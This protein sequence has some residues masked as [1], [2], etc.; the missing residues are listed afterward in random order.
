MV[1]IYCTCM[2]IGQNPPLKSQLAIAEVGLP[3]L[4]CYYLLLRV[5]RL[6]VTPV[7]ETSGPGVIPVAEVSGPAVLPVVIQ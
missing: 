3:C 2:L 6:G 1:L 7:V 4:V 5:S